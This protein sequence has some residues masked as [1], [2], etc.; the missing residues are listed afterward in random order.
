VKRQGTEERM[1]GREGRAV[2]TDGDE[3]VSVHQIVEAVSHA[4]PNACDL[5]HES[6]RKEPTVLAFVDMK[7]GARQ[8]FAELSTTIARAASRLKNLGVRPRDR[9]AVFVGDGPRFV[10]V[11]NALF[12]LGAV[13]V[14]ID[15]GMGLDNVAACV[16]EQRPRALVGV[17][18]AQVLRLVRREA[19]DSIDI[20]VV[21][22]GWFPGANTLRLQGD[23]THDSYLPM[24]RQASTEP[25]A[26]LYTS[27]STGAP[28]GVLYTH[29]ML[30]AQ[31]TAIRDMFDIARGDVDVCCFL[32][33]AL[34]SVAMGTTAVFPDMDFRSPARAKPERIL[35]AITE[36]AG[37]MATSAFASPALWEPFSRWLSSTQT[38]LPGL[39]R[40]L[41]AGA[42]VRPQLHERLLAALPD[43]DVYT[44]YGATEALPVAFMSGREVLA[45]TAAKTRAGA[46]T[47]VGVLAPGVSVRIVQLH[48]DPIPTIFDAVDVPT[49]TI[50]EI[51]VRGPCV[52]RAYDE[53]SERAK[54]ANAAAK[55]VDADAVWHRMGDAGSRDAQGR[56][57]FCGRKSQ[58][59]VKAD[60]VV[61][62]SIPVEAVVETLVDGTG[63]RAALVGV[64]ERGAQRA[65]VW[66]EKGDKPVP[67]L[68]QVQALPGCA[69]VDEVRAFEGAF[70]VDRRH[71]AKIERE[72]LAALAARGHSGG[73]LR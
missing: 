59:V 49:G 73:P 37:R 9:V 6:A 69:A 17:A 42:P 10:V 19:F 47:C 43:G 2:V 51:I 52:T 11:V 40:V 7:T 72:K 46:G 18:R 34:F 58:R 22:D 64:G 33:F 57:W 30:I 3:S 31:V 35:R 21:V 63:Q 54:Q 66:V 16:R 65:V 5:I 60:G 25:A 27:G 23:D 32:P 38:Q 56:L 14:L 20:H 1:P 12:H 68:P 67:S 71:N 28:K 8:T 61:L 29:G 62:H 45:E 48:D 39:K 26:V 53:T 44:P 24:H 13:P 55:I 70:P 50:G 15:P 4:Q 36:G 41:T